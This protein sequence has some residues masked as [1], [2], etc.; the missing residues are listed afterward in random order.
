MTLWD[1]LIGICFA[2]PIG[3]AL[4]S[5]R[6]AKAGLCGYALA[7]TVGIA[8]GACCAWTMRTVGGTV[9][10]HIERYSESL[11]ERYCRVLYFAAMVWI[12]IVVFL[13]KWVSSALLRFVF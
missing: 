10:A 9:Y 1:L 3:G 4:E 8:L 7:I 5:A 11:Q 2:V 6:S 12:V 13:G